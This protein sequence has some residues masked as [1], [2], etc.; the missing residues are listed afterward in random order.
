MLPVSYLLKHC[1]PQVACVALLLMFF[2]L[3]STASD[4]ETSRM[5]NQGKATPG[6][7]G[8]PSLGNYQAR[9]SKPFSWLPNLKAELAD[10]GGV[11]S[12]SKKCPLGEAVTPAPWQ[13]NVDGIRVNI[14][15]REY[16]PLGQ[17][18]CI[19]NWYK[20]KP[21]ISSPLKDDEEGM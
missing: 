18:F 5:V 11:S 1:I 4:Q 16:K 12:A 8:S 6:C 17:P 3:A 10:L 14:W 19:G 20:H 7:I 9:T 21:K 15:R 13:P 2:V